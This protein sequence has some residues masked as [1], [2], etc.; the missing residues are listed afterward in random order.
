MR[1]RVLVQGL[2][3]AAALC[4]TPPT[5]AGVPETLEAADAAFAAGDEAR[6]L[7]LYDQV[8]AQDAENTQALI[9]S[10]M[11]LSWRRSFAEAI[12]RYDRVLA[13]SP[14]NG[15]AL[16][17]RAKV[18]SWSR[19]FEEAEAAFRALL[20]RDPGDRDARLG[21]ARTLSWSG[22]QGAA[23]REYLTVL[24]AHPND[25]EALVGV[26]QT[27]AWSGHPREARRW[28]DKAQEFHPG[29]KEANLG[30]AYLDLARGRTEDA[31]A[32]AADLDRAFP[33][34]P[35]VA[36]LRREIGKAGGPW[37]GAFYDR[38]SDTDDNRLDVYRLEGA[39][40]LSRRVE[41]RG[42]AALHDMRS[43]GEDA[44]AESLYAVLALRA[45][46]GHIVSLR[47][48]ASRLRDVAGASSTEWIGGLVYDWN[49]G[50]DW[51][52]AVAYNHDPLLYSPE[53]LDHRI[54]IDSYAATI[55][56]QLGDYWQVAAEANYWDLSDGARRPLGAFTIKRRWP[57]GVV[58]IETGYAFRW[59]DFDKNL[60]H[61]YF[62]PSNFTAHSLVL[63]LAGPF[64][65]TK[66]YWDLTLEGGVQSFSLPDAHVSNDRVLAATGLVGIPLGRTLTLEVLGAYS[67]FAQQNP[68]GFESRQ[69]GA[70][71]RWRPRS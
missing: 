46:P 25:A 5:L 58:R 67:D 27:Y 55:S 8:L 30:L 49:V 48:G 64:G 65:A 66:A 7:E 63:R 6:A 26:G 71:L 24:D 21:L 29:T 33:R 56:G 15:P 50:G 19:R 40:R 59:L 38:I 28:F 39:G 70:R 20:V 12:A 62:A 60:D 42:G 34:D 35:E 9:R 22:R 32:R 43:P 18:L 47:A 61:G 36:E 2:L 51:S 4:A 3:L 44:R 45:A 52:G 54:I 57:A 41:L 14:E 68:A 1:R 16:H 11:L 37:A 53:I 69:V 23:R 13:K 10:A 17:E 31:E